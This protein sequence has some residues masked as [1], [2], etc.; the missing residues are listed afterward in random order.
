MGER[1]EIEALQR[2]VAEH[3]A[4]IDKL[5]NWIFRY[6]SPGRPAS[7]LPSNPAIVDMLKY[8]EATTDLRLDGA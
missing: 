2:E 5:E 6:E 3:R 1:S 8:D 7:P 4:R